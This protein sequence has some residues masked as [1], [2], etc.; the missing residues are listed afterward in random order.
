MIV[1]P[2]NQ[3]VAFDS[4]TNYI[5]DENCNQINKISKIDGCNVSVFG[6]ALNERNEI[7]I[8]MYDKVLLTD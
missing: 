1:L 4:S 7:Y 6:L 3:I 5:Y 2:N 8:L